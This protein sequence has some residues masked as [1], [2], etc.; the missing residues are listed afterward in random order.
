VSLNTAQRYEQRGAP[1]AFRYTMAGLALELGY[2]PW[3]LGLLRKRTAE[4][5]E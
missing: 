4:P 5:E 1:E 2:D 3:K